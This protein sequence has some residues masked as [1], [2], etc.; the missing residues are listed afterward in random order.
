MDYGQR[1]TRGDVNAIT[2]TTG[3][4]IAFSQTTGGCTLP[5]GTYF[6]PLGGPA[7]GTPNETALASAHLK[8]NA[9]LA[10]TITV[11]TSNFPAKI[12]GTTGQGGDDVTDYDTTAGNWIIENPSTAIVA[13]TGSGNSSTAATVTAG[14]SAAGGCTFHLGNLGTRRARIKVVVATGGVLRV[15][16]HG[17]AGG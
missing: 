13:V 14:G 1:G 9:A 12:G 4:V 16:V 2:I 6:F 15:N 5:A 7:S 3:V 11:E 8:W 10:A 17:K